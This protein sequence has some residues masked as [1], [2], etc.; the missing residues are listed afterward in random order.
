MVFELNKKKYTVAFGYGAF[1][2]LGQC[3]GVKGLKPLMEQIGLMFQDFEELDF[4]AMD[5]LCDIVICAIKEDVDFTSDEL[6]NEFLI[7]PKL[8]ELVSGELVAAF[9]TPS[10]TPQESLGKP[11]RKPKLKA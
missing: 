2:L 4:E 3:W 10:Q 7:N 8:L 6:A 9:P 5:K 11:K 1:R